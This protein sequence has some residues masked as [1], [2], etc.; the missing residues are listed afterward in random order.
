MVLLALMFTQMAS[1]KCSQVQYGVCQH[2]PT[3]A[4]GDT[5]I[6][7]GGCCALHYM[8]TSFMSLSVQS[9][10]VWD[11]DDMQCKWRPHHHTLMAVN[12]NSICTSAWSCFLY[13][14]ESLESFGYLRNALLTWLRFVYHVKV[15]LLCRCCRWCVQ[16]DEVWWCM[17]PCPWHHGT[18]STSHWYVYSRSPA[19]VAH[20]H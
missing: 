13:T 8:L 19:T 14:L 20:C 17:L 4:D 10:Y 15:A 9:S 1:K 5:H 11:A 6:G 16:G 2:L 7:S 3:A 18:Y 12:I